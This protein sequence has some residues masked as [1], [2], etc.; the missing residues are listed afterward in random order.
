MSNIYEGVLEIQKL[1]SQQHHK[2][3]EK[4]KFERNKI[5]SLN[6]YGGEKVDSH[7][8]NRKLCERHASFV[9]YDK[10]CK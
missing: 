5:E 10:I 9:K 3:V 2:I 6:M 8:M 1:L 7:P 4:Q